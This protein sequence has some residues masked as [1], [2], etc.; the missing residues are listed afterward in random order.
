MHEQGKDVYQFE[1][2]S[3]TTCHKYWCHDWMIGNDGRFMK[4]IYRA[5]N[6]RAFSFHLATHIVEEL[7]LSVTNVYCRTASIPYNAL[8]LLTI[9]G[10]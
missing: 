1:D 10:K 6:K 9:G 3:M 8:D 4:Y 5:A 7:D 2:I